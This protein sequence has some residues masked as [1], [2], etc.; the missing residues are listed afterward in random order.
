MAGSRIALQ[1]KLETI[2]GSTN[3]YFQPPASIRL[4]FPC[5]VYTKT[6]QDEAFADDILYSCMRKY[7]VTVIDADPDSTL[8]ARLQ[9]SLRYCSFSSSFP[10]DNLYHNVYTLY[11]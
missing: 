10:A 7:S 11:F 2:L 9:Q 5:I 6:G 4:K 1:E 3:V 8:P